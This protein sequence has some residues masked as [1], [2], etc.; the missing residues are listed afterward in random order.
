MKEANFFKRSLN[1]YGSKFVPFK[2]NPSKTALMI[3]DMQYLCAHPDYGVGPNLKERFS[4]NE[5]E[6]YFHRIAEKVVPN[7]IKLLEYFRGKKLRV[8][9]IVNGTLLPDKS[10]LLPTRFRKL[11][12]KEDFEYNILKEIKPAP[13]ELVINKTSYGAFSSTCI[14]QTLRNMG[15]AYLVITGVGTNVCVET[16]ARDAADRGFRCT[17]VNDACTT[18]NQ[19]MHDATLL[20]YSTWFGKVQNTDEVISELEETSQ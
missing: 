7:Q 4:V 19:Q 16:T 13:N 10:D 15:I 5:A 9:Y 6:S 8:I 18:Y 14:E 3:I 12:H 2:L 17:M 11:P 1:K 20:T